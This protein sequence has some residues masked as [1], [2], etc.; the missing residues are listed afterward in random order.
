MLYSQT[1]SYA[2]QSTHFLTFRI[3]IKRLLIVIFVPVTSNV[4]NLKELILFKFKIETH[5]LLEI[6]KEKKILKYIHHVWVLLFLHVTLKD[7][8]DELKKNELNT[9]RDKKEELLR[10]SLFKSENK[11][12]KIQQL[13]RKPVLAKLTIKICN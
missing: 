3:S 5:K 2:F 1:V 10:N 8:K 12:T 9:I 7:K 13:W 4:P 11:W 6:R